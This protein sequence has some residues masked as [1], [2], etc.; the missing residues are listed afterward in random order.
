MAADIALGSQ[1]TAKL[2]GAEHTF[3]RWLV[4]RFALDLLIEFGKLGGK[5]PHIR[6]KLIGRLEHQKISGGAT[7][8][9]NERQHNQTA[10]QDFRHEIFSP[11]QQWMNR[12]IVLAIT[13]PGDTSCR[14][15]PCGQIRPQSPASHYTCGP[16]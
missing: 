13:Q 8:D 2:T 9:N 3:Q 12:N 1:K 5:R 7:A 14:S 15:A 4:A 10:Q 16:L 11:S 6:G